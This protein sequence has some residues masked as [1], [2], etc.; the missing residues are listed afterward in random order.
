VP[1][2]AAAGPPPAPRIQFSAA[3]IEPNYVVTNGDTLSAIAQ[4]YNTSVDV[5]AAINN[6][7]DRSATLRVGQRLIIPR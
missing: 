7:P 1:D 6:L 3:T 4:R 2:P 5:I